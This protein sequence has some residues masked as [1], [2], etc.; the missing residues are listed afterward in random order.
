MYSFTG[1]LELLSP[2]CIQGEIDLDI[3]SRK[4]GNPN[5]KPKWSGKTKVVR[6]PAKWVNQAIR[7]VSQWDSGEYADIFPPISSKIQEIDVNQLRLD[8]KRFQYKIIHGQSGSTGSLSGVRKWDDNLAGIILVW[9]DPSDGLTYVVNDHNRANLAKSLGANTL[10]CRFIKAIDAAEA[11]QIGAMA[12]IAEGK[13]TALDAAKLFRDKGITQAH[14]VESGICLKEKI[15]KD[16]L[17]LAQIPGYMFDRVIDGSL[18]QS[19]AIAIGSSGLDCDRQGELLKLIERSN[20]AITLEMISELAD[21]VRASETNSVTQMSLFGLEVI[22]QSTAIYRAE[23]Q[24]GIKRQLRRE[25]RLFK[26]VGNSRNAE[27]LQKGNNHIDQQTSQAISSQAETVLR[28]FD[29]LKNQVGP[30]SSAINHCVTQLA[31]G[32]PK[33]EA[34]RE[35]LMLISSEV[36]AMYNA[37]IVALP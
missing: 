22:N 13:G 15:A 5:F 14:L 25:S 8:P 30:I 20:R 11:R 37:K 16:G 27:E 2:S 34:I 9:V 24:A 21:T 28:H 35:C 7:I 12:N 26:T 29:L 33:S 32:K 4:R 3:T 18:E 23:V 6:L 36:E 17:A 31:N 19:V 10:V 1:Q